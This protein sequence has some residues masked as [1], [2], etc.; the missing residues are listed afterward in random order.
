MRLLTDESCD[1][2]IVAAL[3]AAGQV[4]EVGAVARQALDA[5]V[6]EMALQ[7]A[8]VLLTEDKDFGELVYSRGARSCGVI[9]MRYPPAARAAIERMVVELARS[10]GDEIANRFVVV[11]PGRIRISQNPG[12]PPPPGDSLPV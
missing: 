12:A 7:D 4:V 6:I 11:S 2:H 8:R 9:L 5:R 1:G 10:R 3:R